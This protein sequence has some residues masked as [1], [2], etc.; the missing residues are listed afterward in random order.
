M[1]IFNLRYLKAVGVVT[2][3]IGFV[4]MLAMLPLFASVS[5]VHASSSSRAHYVVLR[6]D[7]S[8]VSTAGDYI[9]YVYTAQQ[10]T[11]SSGVN[12]IAGYMAINVPGFLAGMALEVNM[13]EPDDCGFMGKCVDWELHSSVRVKCLRGIALPTGFDCLSTRSDSVVAMNTWHTLEFVTY[14]QGF[15]IAR[16]RNYST[17]EVADIAQILDPHVTI[18]RMDVGT[19]YNDDNPPYVPA[20]IYH[21]HP[22]YMVAGT[23]FQ[24]WPASSSGHNNILVGQFLSSQECPLIHKASRNV[25]NDPRYWSLG[26]IDFGNTACSANPMF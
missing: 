25:T 21:W 8:A 5:P 24:L 23:G 7:L 22:S 14:N 26:F 11:Q 1:H 19:V 2:T 18:T 10:P 20:T 17:G 16:I 13:S 9:H 6:T 15:W 12:S 4:T 3:H